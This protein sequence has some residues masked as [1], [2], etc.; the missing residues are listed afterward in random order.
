MCDRMYDI[1]PVWSMDSA[2]GGFG[3]PEDGASSGSRNPQHSAAQKR[4]QQTQA[5]VNEVVD[6]M[7]SNIDKVLDRDAKLSEL[8]NRA[9]ALQQGASQFE[10][11]AGKLKRKYWWKNLKMMLIMGVIGAVI[12]IVII[13]DIIPQKLKEG[14]SRFLIISSMVSQGLE[15]YL[16]LRKFVKEYLDHQHG[17]QYL[18]LLLAVNHISMNVNYPTTLSNIYKYLSL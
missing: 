8:D 10:Q 13:V 5:Q 9:D 12:L 4:I 14:H 6:I 11:Q 7:K 17:Q 16:M 1:I 18:Q 2:T 3:L 15:N